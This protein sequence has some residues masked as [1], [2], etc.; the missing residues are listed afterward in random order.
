MKALKKKYPDVFADDNDLYPDYETYVTF[1]DALVSEEL[2]EQFI[3]QL[4][5]AYCRKYHH[6]IFA[7]GKT[8]ESARIDFR[9]KL[10]TLQEQGKIPEKEDLVAYRE[11]KLKKIAACKNGG[12]KKSIKGLLGKFSLPGDWQEKRTMLAANTLDELAILMGGK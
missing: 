12:L 11:A 7:M 1:A 9:K 3:Q 5:N 4:S 6:T 2:A 10:E 8:A